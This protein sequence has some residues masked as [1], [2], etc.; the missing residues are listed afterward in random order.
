MVN[1]R[2]DALFDSLGRLGYY[3]YSYILGAQML[4]GKRDCGG[5]VIF[6]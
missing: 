5:K 3:E 4:C 1:N 6:M 2:G